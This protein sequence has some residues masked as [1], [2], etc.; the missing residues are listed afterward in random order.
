[1]EQGGA[2]AILY[3]LDRVRL[4]RD[5]DKYGL[6]LSL[7]RR[8]GVRML[9]SGSG[10]RQISLKSWPYLVIPRHRRVVSHDRC[11]PSGSKQD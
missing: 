4:G 2:W 8:L 10:Y 6:L 3:S 1:M 5:D 9:L 7:P 11:E